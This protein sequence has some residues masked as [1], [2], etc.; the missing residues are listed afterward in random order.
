MKWTKSRD[1]SAGQAERN[2]W[3]CRGYAAVLLAG[4]VL[5]GA[6][7][8]GALQA[9]AQHA[10]QSSQQQSSG[11][12]PAHEQ[13]PSPVSSPP[14][15]AVPSSQSGTQSLGGVS[16]DRKKQIADESANLLKLATDLKAE[17]DK[18]TKDTLSINVIRKADQIEKL[19][20]NVKEQMKV[21]AAP[22]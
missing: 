20:H 6:V 16:T 1:R 2:W 3:R 14:P 7:L 13:G 10:A 18:T 5:S 11:N 12:Q 21:T 22:N 15:Q 17:V 8:M 19:A 9:V 4:I